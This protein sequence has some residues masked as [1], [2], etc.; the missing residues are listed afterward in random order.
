MRGYFKGLLYCLLFFSIT[1]C[2]SS[3]PK[4]ADSPTKE[5]VINIAKEQFIKSGFT[6]LLDKLEFKIENVRTIEYQKDIDRYTC[7][8]DLILINKENHKTSSLPITYTVQKT[9]DGNKFYV[10]VYG[11]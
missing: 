6:N 11:L 7:K 9:D 3:T 10:E 8:A 2:S 5:L 4:C 1:A